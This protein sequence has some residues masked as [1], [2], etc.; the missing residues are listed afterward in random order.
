M[1]VRGRNRKWLGAGSGRI[2]WVVGVNIVCEFCPRVCGRWRGMNAFVVV[3]IIERRAEVSHH[4]CVRGENRGWN[5]RGS[6]NREK[7]ADYGEL[8]MDFFFLDIEKTSDMLDH[9]LMGESHF[10][11]SRAVRRRGS[12]NV[13]G[14]ASTIGRRGGARWDKDGRG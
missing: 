2:V 12:D 7:G 1:E 5:R 13:G 10:V 14:V 8:A 11:T 4:K 3:N 9:L 6:V